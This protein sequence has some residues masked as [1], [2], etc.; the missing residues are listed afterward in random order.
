MNSVFMKL[1]VLKSF[2]TMNEAPLSV[3]SYVHHLGLRLRVG[4]SF[5]LVCDV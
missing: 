4:R 3:L 2:C 5:Q 1:V